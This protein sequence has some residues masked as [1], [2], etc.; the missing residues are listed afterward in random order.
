MLGG[1]ALVAS[2]VCDA[3]C[4]T[5]CRRAVATGLV[6]PL[7]PV[8]AGLGCPLSSAVPVASGLGVAASDGAVAAG[9]VR[10]L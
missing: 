7:A 3:A 9:L 4:W 6:D 2:E 10:P 8:A 5:G 1:T